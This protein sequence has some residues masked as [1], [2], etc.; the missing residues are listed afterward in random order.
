MNRRRPS[1][2]PTQQK[3]TIMRCK[4]KM[5]PVFDSDTCKDFLKKE[6]EESNNICKN[7]KHSF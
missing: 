7:C 5:I 3:K 2:K 1:N 6:N 4:S